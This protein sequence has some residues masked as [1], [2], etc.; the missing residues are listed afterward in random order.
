MLKTFGKVA[1]RGFL[2][3]AALVAGGPAVVV[4]ARADILGLDNGANYTLNNSGT[5]GPTV[6][7]G[8]ATLTDN[9]FSE[10]RSLYYNTPQNISG[11]FQAAFT[12][13]AAGGGSGGPADGITFDLQN[14]GIHALGAGGNGL[15]YRGIAPS[16]AVEFNVY[17]LNVVGTAY[18]TNGAVLGYMST[19]PVDISSGD[20]IAVTLTNNA[21]TNTLTEVLKDLN[22]GNT[23]STSYSTNLAA[24]LGG[25][26]ALV[27]FTGGTGGGTSI[28]TVS[29]FSFITTATV[30]EPASLGM[31]G[32]G[33]LGVI[34]YAWNRRKRASA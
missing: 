33:V 11:G 12:Y 32:M 27:G 30:P 28:Q 18:H 6:S 10:A 7:G 9:G 20:Q 25:S 26:T 23:F 16:A 8:T 22:N 13:R 19:A 14:Q 15:G 17:A 5:G 2:L 34:G 21:S 1:S 24:V 31:L 29:D 3:A 4:T